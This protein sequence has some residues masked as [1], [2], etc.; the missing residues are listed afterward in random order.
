[1]LMPSLPERRHRVSHLYAEHSHAGHP[2]PGH[3]HVH[4]PANF[5]RVFAIAAVLNISL[6]VIRVVYGVLAHSI[7]LLP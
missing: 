1:M 6:V 7:A 5:G 3:S 4:A 2:H